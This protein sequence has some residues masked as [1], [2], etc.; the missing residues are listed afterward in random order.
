M[1][2]V[3]FYLLSGS[4]PDNKLDLIAK[5]AEKACGRGSRVYIYGSQRNELKSV[6]EHLWTF[7]PM[8]F[9][10]HRLLAED[11]HAVNDIDPVLMG[12]SEPSSDRQILINLHDQVPFFF[13]RFER[14]LEIVGSTSQEQ[15]QGRARYRFYQ[16]RGYPLNHHKL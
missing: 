10:A 2:R 7:R 12:T 3:D 13:S 16:A 11:Q 4:E 14:A 9:V 6:D 8:S 1:T 5:L 15:E